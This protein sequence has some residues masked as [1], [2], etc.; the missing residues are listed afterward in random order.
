MLQ[1]EEVSPM[2][3]YKSLMNDLS[4][5]INHYHIK[6]DHEVVLVYKRINFSV[7]DVSLEA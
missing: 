6:L 4:S 7:S 5:Y 1:P 3:I 2:Q